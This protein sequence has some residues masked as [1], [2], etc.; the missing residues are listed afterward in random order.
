MK[1]VYNTETKS[2]ESKEVVTT[3][4]AYIAKVNGIIYNSENQQYEFI[5]NTNKHYK[6]YPTDKPFTL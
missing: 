3:S 4:N 2:Y 1:K 5:N 6:E